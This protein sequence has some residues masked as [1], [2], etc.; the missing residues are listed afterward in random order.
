MSEYSEMLSTLNEIINELRNHECNHEHC[1]I[2]KL[3]TEI[4]FND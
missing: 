3:L 1:C 2:R 4:E